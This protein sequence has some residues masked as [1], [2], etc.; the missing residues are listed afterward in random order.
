[1]NARDF[2]DKHH[3]T[4]VKY[5]RGVGSDDFRC[6]NGEELQHNY[7][8]PLFSCNTKVADVSPNERKTRGRS[9][10]KITCAGDI[11]TRVFQLVHLDSP[12]QTF[13]TN[14][15][16]SCL[17][18]YIYQHCTDEYPI[19]NIVHW[20]QFGVGPFDNFRHALAFISVFIIQKPCLVLLHGDH[21]TKGRYWDMFIYFA[22]NLVFVPKAP[23]T[24][25]QNRTIVNAANRADIGRLD[26]LK[27]F[28]GIYLDRDQVI[29]RPVD[30]FRETAFSAFQEGP[31]G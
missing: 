28:G 11:S 1:M 27:E 14:D 20:I 4:F 26:V 19:P 7:S 21:P 17:H 10:I 30:V 5:L 29:L 8:A 6:R 9:Q 15:S 18:K 16:R 13:A 23:Q 2:N 22:K 25:I 12:L 31:A 3:L 24:H